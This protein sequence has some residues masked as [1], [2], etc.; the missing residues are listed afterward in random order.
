MYPTYLTKA[1]RRT[2][3]EPTPEELSNPDYDPEK[4]LARRQE[5]LALSN[6]NNAVKLYQTLSSTENPVKEYNYIV[7]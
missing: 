2:V 7:T 5:E 1:M 3:S 6:S 4:D